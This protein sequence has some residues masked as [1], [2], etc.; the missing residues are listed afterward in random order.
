MNQAPENFFL[1]TFKSFGFAFKGIWI[2]FRTPSNAWVHLVAASL[3]CFGG[4]W[5]GISKTE[6]IAVIFAIAFVL[7]AEMLNT[8]IEMLCNL[9]S[10]GYN[11]L[12]GKLKD[13]S[14]GAV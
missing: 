13:V 6:W 10:P 14:A 1:R 12:A 7:V 3:A 11:D 2:F 9:A 5:F 4:Y 8:A